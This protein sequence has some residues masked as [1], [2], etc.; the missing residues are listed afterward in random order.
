ML[1][2][3]ACGMLLVA[4][5]AAAPTDQRCSPPAYCARTDRKV[6]TYTAMPPTLGPAGSIIT[7]PTFG[8]RIARATDAGTDPQRPDISFFTPASAEQNSWNTNSTRFFATNN[9]GALW[10]FDFDPNS[11]KTRVVEKLKMGWKGAQFSFRQPDI[12]YGIGGR[13]GIFQQYDVTQGKVSDIHNATSCTSLKADDWGTNISVSADDKRL[14]GV[15]GP[16]QGKNYLVYVYDRDKGC[17]WYNTQTGE[18]GGKWGPQGSITAPYRFGIHDARISKSGEYVEVSGGGQGPIFW[19]VDT[20]DVALCANKENQCWG[21]HAM[22]YAHLVNSFNRRHPLELAERPLNDLK[23]TRQILDP[24]SVIGWYDYHISWNSS[25]PEDSNPA[26]FSTY[27]K[28]NPNTPRAPL[29]VSGPWENEI[30][31][32]EMDGKG[33]TVWRFAHTYSTGR[34]GFWSQPRG[35]VS[36]DGRFFMFTSDWQDQLGLQPNKKFYR[37]DVFIVELR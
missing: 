32:I 17:R 15:F 27:R 18:I 3:F 35:N 5:A 10:L 16:E 34:N 21:H 33:S 30:D 13:S 11:M 12:L 9:G 7:D 2:G 25:G 8:S 19:H 29:V 23:A 22:G 37:T 6:E 36:P 26:C 28:G 14:M 1:A 20:L 4:G 24:P 31:C